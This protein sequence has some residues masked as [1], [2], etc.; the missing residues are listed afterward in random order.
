MDKNEKQI[1]NEIASHIGRLLR[2]AFGKGPQ[3]IFVNI[4][5]PFI[6]IYLR[7]FL[8]PTEKILLQQ[9]QV[10]SVQHTRDLVMK[11][12]IPEIKAYLLLL[13]NMNIR[14]FYYDWGWDNH[15]GI[16]VGME[17]EMLDARQEEWYA[18][19][20]E[21]HREID[22]IS[23][24]IQKKPDKTDSYMINDRTLLIVRTGILISLGKEMLRLGFEESLKLAERNLEKN[25]LFNNNQF[26]NIIK[27]QILEVFVDWDFHLDKSVIVFILNPNQK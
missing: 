13:T 23:Q 26:Q 25:Y 7:N 16:L 1:Q 10:N 22:R 2:E 14:E 27:S 15:S 24:L 11:S 4:S 21:L 17:P 19:K 20:E 9:D 18:G 8:S 12:L 3:S 6:V 5:R